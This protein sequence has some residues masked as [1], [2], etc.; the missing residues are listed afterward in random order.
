MKFMEFKEEIRLSNESI[1]LISE[2]VTEFLEELKMERKN[3]LRI[4]LLVEEILLDWQ[5]HF[6]ENVSCYVKMGKRFGKH[7]LSLEVEGGEFNPLNKVS[8]EY[9]SYRDRLLANMG[10]A[11]MYTYGHEKNH[12]VFKFRKQKANPIVKLAVAVVAA[13]VVGFLGMQL[14]TGMRE[15]VLN[16]VLIPIYDTFFNLLGTIAGPMVFLSVAWGIYGIGDTL[17]N[18]PIIFSFRSL[19]FCAP[20]FTA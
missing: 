16:G 3:I 14:P 5:E 1:D 15:A 20:L 6:S 7:Y 9:G 19:I 12:M 2:K 13:L 4:R 11:P 10:L 8:E 17:S 18:S